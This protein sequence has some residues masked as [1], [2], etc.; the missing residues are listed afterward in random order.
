MRAR[1]HAVAST[2]VLFLTLATARVAHADTS[3]STVSADNADAPPGPAVMTEDTEHDDSDDADDDGSI[4]RADGTVRGEHELFKHPDVGGFLVAGGWFTEVGFCVPAQ[5]G[6]LT[7]H[8]CEHFMLGTQDGENVSGEAM[9][10]GM[11]I[12][13]SSAVRVTLGGGLSFGSFLANGLACALDDA[14]LESSRDRDESATPEPNT[15]SCGIRVPMMVYPSVSVSVRLP[16]PRVNLVATTSVRY[17]GAAPND[18]G[19]RPPSGLAAGV[20]LGLGI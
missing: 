2:I 8:A 6:Q 3:R 17:I 14:S 16:I 4:R 1:V 11:H 18:D 5:K 20:S 9:S 10:V 12:R 7:L 15:T 19:D 13:A